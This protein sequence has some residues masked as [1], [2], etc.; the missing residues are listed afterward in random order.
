MFWIP[1]SVLSAAS[2]SFSDVWRKKSTQ[3][4]DEYVAAWS[5][6]SFSFILLLP[7]LP[8]QKIPPLDTA[9]WQALL[10]SGSLNVIATILYMKA[11]KASDLSITAPMLSFTPLFLLVT[12]PLIMGEFPNPVGLFGILLI[13]VGAYVLNIGK[14]HEG[15]IAPFRALL[16]HDG[17]KYMLLVAF[18]FSISANFDKIGVLHSSPYVWIFFLQGFVSLGTLPVMLMKSSRRMSQIVKNVKPLS[19]ISI[20]HTLSNLFHV[21]ALQFGLVAYVISIRR[22]SV[23]WGVVFGYMIF[24]EKNMKERLVGACVMTAGVLCIALS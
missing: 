12:S 9:F 6:V 20:F 18:L 7:G 5:A 15:Y 21:T 19:L 17:A 14:R 23:L 3:R 24:K 22:T 10:I 16:S 13:V 2:L 4:V 1:F 8:F 11:Y